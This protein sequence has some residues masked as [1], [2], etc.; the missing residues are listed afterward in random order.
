MIRRRITIAAGVANW[1]W[2][3]RDPLLAAGRASRAAASDHREE[4][5]GQPA[6]AEDSGH[7]IYLNP[8]ADDEDGGPGDPP[9]VGPSALP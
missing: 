9:A 5:P 4:A 2:L 7:R 8:W 1:L 3:R 6:D